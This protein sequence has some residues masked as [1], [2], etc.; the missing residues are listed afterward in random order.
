MS[1]RSKLNNG[2]SPK[3][4]LVITFYTEVIFE[5]IICRH[6]RNWTTE[7][8]EKFQWSEHLTQMS[9]SV[10]SHIESLEIEQRK[11]SWNSNGHSFSLGGPIQPHR[12]S[13]RSKLNKGS[14]W[15]I[16][17]VQTFHLDIRFRHI[18]YRDARNWT[19][20]ALEQF[21][22]SQLFTRMSDSGT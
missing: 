17:M 3:I 6:A 22:W 20:E 11:L 2:I 14:S 15:E 12:I 9:D 8:L 18:I 10:V 19:M 16:P 21:K 1:R 5:R 13:R 4:Q 7:A